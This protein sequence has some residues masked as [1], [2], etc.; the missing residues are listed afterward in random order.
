MKL[1][2]DLLPLVRL[3]LA[4]GRVSRATRYEDGVTL[5]SDTDHTVM[6]ALI[7]AATAPEDLSATRVVAM[8][9][10]HDLVEALVGDV[11][12]L[13]PTPEILETKRAAEAAGLVALNA[14][15]CDFPVLKHWIRQYEEQ[16]IPEARWVRII[17]K[18][19][20]KLTHALNGCA[21]ARDAGV[22]LGELTRLHAAQEQKLRIEY[23]ERG[24]A[25]AHHLLT[26]A[27]RLAEDSYPLEPR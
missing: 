13:N 21:A 5:E 26:D 17:D 1:R 7:A 22:S 12:T 2:P 16:V 24:M 14:V 3:S 27:C 6:L 23:P 15:L 8:A 4:L 10:V 18:L 11:S 20:P 19:T 9:L 25:L